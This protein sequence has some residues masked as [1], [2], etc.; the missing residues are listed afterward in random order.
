MTIDIYQSN[1]NRTKFLAVP[2][3]TNPTSISVP[4]NDYKSLKPFKD[5]IEIAVGDSRAG[6]DSAAAM[7]AITRDGFYIHGAVVNVSS[8]EK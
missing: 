4:G 1:T 3:G 7:A 5:N 6:F 2:A 8:S